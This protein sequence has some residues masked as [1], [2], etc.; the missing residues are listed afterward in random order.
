MKSKGAQSQKLTCQHE[1]VKKHRI[2]EEN[3][4]L[5]HF[6]VFSCKTIGKHRFVMFCL[7]DIKKNDLKL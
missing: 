4:K 6:V 1:H 2:D 3:I 5:K 7:D